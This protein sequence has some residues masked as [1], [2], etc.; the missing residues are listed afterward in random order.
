LVPSNLDRPGRLPHQQGTKRGEAGL[1]RR[2]TQLGAPG[3]GLERTYGEAA[4]RG[5]A[6]GLWRVY[7]PPVLI[8]PARRL[9]WSLVFGGCAFP[10]V[11]LDPATART[12]SWESLEGA[13][14]PL[15]R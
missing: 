13:L 7:F 5:G 9:L 8:R 11:S 1:P 14:S 4:V 10:P 12:G 3:P 15:S 2:A 6:F